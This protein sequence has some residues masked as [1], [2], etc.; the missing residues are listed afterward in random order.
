MKWVI[1]RPI[2]QLCSLQ[3]PRAY[4]S[5]LRPP[6]LHCQK[7]P[8]LRVLLRLRDNISYQF[9]LPFRLMAEETSSSP[10]WRFSCRCHVEAAHRATRKVNHAGTVP[11]SMRE[12]M[13]T[14]SHIIIEAPDEYYSSIKLCS[15]RQPLSLSS[16]PLQRPRHVQGRV[17]RPR[18]RAGTC[19]PQRPRKPAGARQ[20]PRHDARKGREPRSA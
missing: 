8:C 1:G 11:Q 12:K 16:A 5:F 14:M 20:C 3:L 18:L 15:I 17:P 9:H 10:R 2:I 7:H 4:R 13:E 6:L 19:T